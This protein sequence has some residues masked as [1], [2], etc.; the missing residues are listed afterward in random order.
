MSIDIAVMIQITT[1]KNHGNLKAGGRNTGIKSVNIISHQKGI[2][3]A[4]FGL[5]TVSNFI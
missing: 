3:K 2:N 1:K 4:D 5:I